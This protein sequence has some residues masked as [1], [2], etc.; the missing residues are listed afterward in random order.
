MHLRNS[1]TTNGNYIMLLPCNGQY[2]QRWEID[3]ENHFIRSSLNE[4]KCMQVGNQRLA[5]GLSLKI[6]D[7]DASKMNQKWDIRSSGEIVSKASF[8]DY[9]LDGNLFTAAIDLWPCD[10]TSDQYWTIV[11][12]TPQPSSA[13]KAPTSSPK[14]SFTS[15]PSILPSSL[16]SPS[17]TDSFDVVSIQFDEN[18]ECMDLPNSNLTPSRDIMLFK[19]DQ[20]QSQK[21]VIDPM[22]FIRSAVDQT[23]CIG[24][25]D[26]DPSSGAYIEIQNCA[27]KNTQRWSILPN[28][29]I[30]SHGTIVR[31]CMD[32]NSKTKTI[33]LWSC[34]ETP[35]Q[36]W[37]IIKSFIRPSAFPSTTIKPSPMPSIYP[38]SSPSSNFVAVMIRA[39]FNQH[40]LA[41]PNSNANANGVGII[42]LPCTGN[43]NQK[44]I[45]DGAGYIHSS[46]NQNKCI[47][48]RTKTSIY[49]GRKIE[50]SNCVRGK[51]E[52]QFEYNTS[53]KEIRARGGIATYCMDGN[54]PGEIVIMW[55]CD[56]SFDQYWT[57][58]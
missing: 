58:L 33:I 3:D 27:K 46:I 45:I 6:Q 11:D 49:D 28:G 17:P 30:Q 1:D 31:R 12:P 57:L 40:C 32:G 55:A 25:E 35:D 13:T 43:N 54:D 38:S 18:G 48:V 20:V 19:C 50:L 44:W 52:Q 9:C 42:L 16:P 53:T 10:T 24:I 15:R 26:N 14:P 4:N 23:K 22:G 36:Y 47:Q 37:S 34:D 7:C 41:L 8:I 21:W 51:I 56:E 2:S 5:A 39:N 29:E